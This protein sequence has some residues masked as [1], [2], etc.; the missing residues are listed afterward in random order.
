MWI[1]IARPPRPDAPQWTGRRALALFD[2]VAW[3]GLWLAV[4]AS[5]PFDVGIGGWTAV[6]V[7][8]F[9]AVRRAY[10]A[11]WRNERYWFTTVRWGVP[12]VWLLA[13]GLVLKLL[14]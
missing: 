2:A 10:R 3:P 7:L 14:A 12:V 6:A 5:A 9:A 1:F 13:G 8:G 11:I 4:I